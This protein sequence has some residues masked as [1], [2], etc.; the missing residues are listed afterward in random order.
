M[1]EK[2]IVQQL[3][4]FID[5]AARNRFPANLWLADLTMEV[6]VRRGMHVIDEGITATTLDIA[7]VTVSEP[8]RGKG[9]FT[10]FFKEACRR[11]PWDGVYIESVL[12]NR[13]AEWC[14]N[15][16]LFE[17]PHREPPA[18]FMRC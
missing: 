17:V 1:S 3:Q 10:Q 9:L 16:G 13:L 4:D 5:H 11:Q 15:A 18:F 8:L 12:N 14:R 2:P 6:Y 7:N